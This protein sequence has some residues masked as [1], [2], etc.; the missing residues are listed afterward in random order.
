MGLR[1]RGKAIENLYF[2]E[3]ELSF[4]LHGMRSRLMGLWAASLMRKEDANSYASE[5]VAASIGREGD[6]AMFNKLHDD[7]FAA[8]V[9][10]A[11][12]TIHDQM[13]SLL[14]CAVDE[15]R[16]GLSQFDSKRAA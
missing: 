14:R 1:Q 12:D 15:L 6:E 8:G 4:R 11:D 7:F 2:H 16:N 3:E 5:I 13:S 9:G 10:V